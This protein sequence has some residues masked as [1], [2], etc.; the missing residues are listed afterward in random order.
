MK[1][2]FTPIES[3]FTLIELLISIAV[4]SII[5]AFGMF[6]FQNALA[7]GRDSQRRSDLKQLQT[8]I[9]NYHNDFG[10]YPAT[11]GSGC[12]YDTNRC[13]GAPICGESTI[14]SKAS[15]IPNLAPKYIRRLPSDPRVNTANPVLNSI[16]TA[17]N[18]AGTPGYFYCSDGK[19]YKVMAICGP[20]SIVKD[21]KFGF[22]DPARCN[23]ANGCYSW[24]IYTPGA[25]SW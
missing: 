19:D 1:S 12:T 7:K 21:S 3:G 24:A 15:Y 13:N 5:T 10:T 20:E 6:S 23:A 25:A 18:T 17:C 4:I 14:G 9:E 11:K 2:R 16:T 22:W 8:A